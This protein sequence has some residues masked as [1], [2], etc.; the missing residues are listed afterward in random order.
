MSDPKE[1]SNKSHELGINPKI[2]FLKKNARKRSSLENLENDTRINDLNELINIERVEDDIL[3]EKK[4]IIHL[5]GKYQRYWLDRAKNVIHKE[6]LIIQPNGK[7]IIRANKNIYSGEARYVLNSLLQINI[8]SLNEF[9][10][11]ALTLLAYVGRHDFQDIT[12]LHTYSLSASLD[13]T[14]ICTYEILVPITSNAEIAIPQL[15]EVDSTEF[16]KMKFRFPELYPILSKVNC[17]P[18]PKVEWH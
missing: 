8:D 7:A 3:N 1:N 16:V 11:I 4:N 6:I 10:D 18:P 2:K 5:K 14:P 15:I 17:T 13:N 9:E 12:C